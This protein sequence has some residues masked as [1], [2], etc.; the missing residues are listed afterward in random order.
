MPRASAHEDSPWEYPLEARVELKGLTQNT[1][2]NGQSGTVISLL[3][4][5]VKSF[6]TTHLNLESVNA[7]QVVRL[8]ATNKTMLVR[9]KNL[10][11]LPRS[12]KTLNKEECLVVLGHKEVPVENDQDLESLR[13]AILAHLRP[14]VQWYKWQEKET[15]REIGGLLAEAHA[16]RHV[17][18]YFTEWTSLCEL[19]LCETTTVVIPADSDNDPPQQWLGG[20]SVGMGTD[21]IPQN[22]FYARLHRP[23]KPPQA[24]FMTK[25]AVALLENEP[26]GRELFQQLCEG[27]LKITYDQDLENEKFHIITSVPSLGDDSCAVLHFFPAYNPSI[28]GYRPQMIEMLSFHDLPHKKICHEIRTH[29]LHRFFR[30]MAAYLSPKFRYAVYDNLKETYQRQKKWKLMVD[31]SIAMAD[32]K[33]ISGDED[34]AL[35]MLDVGEALEAT[36]EHE[37]AAFV[38]KDMAALMDEN[39]LTNQLQ[40]IRRHSPHNFAGVAWYRIGKYEAAMRE[41]LLSLKTLVSQSSGKCLVNHCDTNELLN[42]IVQTYDCTFDAALQK[43]EDIHGEEIGKAQTAFQ[44]YLALL[45]A[46]GYQHDDPKGFLERAK[47]WLQV[48]RPQHKASHDAAQAALGRTIQR[49]TS[50]SQFNELLINDCLVADHAKFKTRS[51][52]IDTGADTKKF[53]STKRQARNDMDRRYNIKGVHAAQGCD[54]PSC[55][56]KRYFT[57]PKK[58]KDCP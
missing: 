31:L 44:T 28:G 14:L 55:E 24:P 16:C 36:G 18:Q 12:L 27:P 46:A 57:D 33:F 5:C 13:S 56:M 32:A 38:Y 10:C 43:G 42:K 37:K 58:F 3:R 40:I 20:L 11:Y 48:L 41:Y 15:A 53:L 9:P 50:M 8:H 35:G 52:I 30:A 4:N 39:R 1:R 34:T 17:Q 19:K 22:T 47:Q 51:R 29:L 23:G 45:N 25:E 6:Y 49:S 21:K 7:R 2:L 26:K 54:N